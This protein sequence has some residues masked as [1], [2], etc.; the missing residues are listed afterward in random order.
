LFVD[1]LELNHY[2]NSESGKLAFSQMIYW[3]RYPEGLHVCEWR[4]VNESHVVHKQDS[5]YVDIIINSKF[6]SLKVYSK[7][8][9]E[10]KTFY[11]PELKDKQVF[12]SDKRNF[13]YISQH[14]QAD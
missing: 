9:R 3:K 11:D 4:M 12:S 10:T 13:P 14:R 6:E 7:V 8:F 1:Q 5:Y 2:Y